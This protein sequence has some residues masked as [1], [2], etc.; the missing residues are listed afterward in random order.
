MQNDVYAA[1]RDSERAFI[2][3][4]DVK[5]FLNEGYVDLCARLQMPEV[6][7]TGTTGSDGTITLPSNFVT[8]KR[9]IIDETEMLWTMSDVFINHQTADTGSSLYRIWDDVIET[10]PLAEDLAYT[11]EYIKR[12]TEM[13]ADGDTAAELPQ[14]LH[15]RLVAYARATCKLIEGEYQDYQIWW[16]KYERGLPGPPR[17]T[18]RRT[19]GPIAM[20]P[21]RTSL[22]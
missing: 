8:M 22:W 2:D 9:L 17:A 5:V 11:M 12:P 4:D 18:Y 6:T 21:E 14:E 10:W 7:V 15:P 16:D 20:I 1:L 13:S 3:V 19:P